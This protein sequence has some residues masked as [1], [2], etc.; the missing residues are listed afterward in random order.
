MS[1]RDDRS[2]GYDR[3]RGGDRRGY[4]RRERSP[5]G[6][7][8]GRGSYRDE[9]GPVRSEGYR[10]YEDSPRRGSSRGS[11]EWH[12]GSTT[13]GRGDSS[14]GTRGPSSRTDTTLSSERLPELPETVEIPTDKGRAYAGVPLREP[15]GKMGRPLKVMVNHFAIESLP[16]IKV[17][18]ALLELS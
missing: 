8:S 5:R 13:S 15:R 17:C 7:G 10:Q 16:I 18:Q 4:D 1:G 12:H 9:R 11:Y 6:Y 14:F 2:R 3:D